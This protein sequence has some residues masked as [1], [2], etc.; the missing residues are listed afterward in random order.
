MHEVNE[1][2]AQIRQSTPLLNVFSIN[3]IHSVREG[4]AAAAQ[5]R[6]PPSTGA[7]LTQRIQTQRDTRAD[8][9]FN[10]RPPDLAP[11]PITIYHPVFA[12]FLRLMAEPPDPTPEDLGRAHDFVC[13][14]SA[15]YKDEAERVLKLSRNLNAA[16]Y[17]GILGIQKLSYTSSKLAPDGVVFSERTPSGF[18]TITAILEVK[19][20]IGE[21][22]SDPIAQA[23]CAYVA[24]YSSDEVFRLCRCSSWCLIP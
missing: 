2:D 4:I 10:Y 1:S 15:Y 21:G 18:S 17:H 23:E 9:V 12:K 13:L 16:V 19:A 22:N 11:P 14:A 7:H 8:A 6:D 3:G 20:E 5:K 24:V